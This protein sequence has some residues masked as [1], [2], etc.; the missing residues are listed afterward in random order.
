MPEVS[1]IPVRLAPHRVTRDCNYCWYKLNTLKGLQS[2][3]YVC[4][5][6]MHSARQCFRH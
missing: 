6:S 4:P 3:K 1:Q 2:S 5:K